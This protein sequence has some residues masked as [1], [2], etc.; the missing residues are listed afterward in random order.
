MRYRHVSFDLVYDGSNSSA[1]EREPKLKF[2]RHSSEWQRDLERAWEMQNSV[3]RRRSR[4]RSAVKRGKIIRKTLGRAYISMYTPTWQF[5][6][7]PQVFMLMLNELRNENANVPYAAKPR[8]SR[9][10]FSF[11]VHSRGA[12]FTHVSLILNLSATY[13][14]DNRSKN[15]EPVLQ[16]PNYHQQDLISFSWENFLESLELQEDSSKTKRKIFQARYCSSLL[17]KI[18]SLVKVFT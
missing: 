18:C 16:V 9:R 17:L 3:S 13:R 2:K 12:W 14:Q 8:K 15:C 1:D 4:A 5:A 11:K 10:T 6:S 7:S